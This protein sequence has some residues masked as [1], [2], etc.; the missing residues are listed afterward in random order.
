[1]KKLKTNS[2]LSYLEKVCQFWIPEGHM[3]LFLCQSKDDIAQWGET[4]I[5]SLV[6]IYIHSK[7]FICVK[8]E[9][10]GLS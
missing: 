9:L 5:Y 6:K 4:F 7:H 2:S 1:M 10:L 8:K 3:F